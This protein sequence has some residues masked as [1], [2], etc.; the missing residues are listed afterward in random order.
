[1][2]PGMHPDPSVCRVGRDFYL[3]CSSFEYFP[4]VPISHSRD[5]V[6]WRP[7]GHALTRRSQLDLTGVPSSGGIYAPTLRHH[8]GTF[9]LVTTLVGRGHLVVT[10]RDPGGPWSDPV[11]LAGDGVDPSLGF[12]DG[13]VYLTRTGKGS[14]PDHPF[15]HQTELDRLS[16]ARRP[17]S[18]GG[19][20]AASGRK[21]HTC[22][23]AGPGTTSSPRRAGRATA[24]PS[25]S[26][27]AAARTARSSRLRT[28]RS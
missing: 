4:G 25:S 26:G 16:S 14:D 2:L 10:A 21:G 5:L 17:A 18:S 12:L 8:D 19:A 3:A 24:T 1:M 23:A 27:A 15:I 22:T 13:R 11:W 6:S 7:L 20:R 28:G 9:F